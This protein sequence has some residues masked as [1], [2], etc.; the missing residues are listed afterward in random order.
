MSYLA[1]FGNDFDATLTAVATDSRINVLSKPR[2]QTSDG[3]AASLKV[4]N[5]VPYVTGTYFGGINGQ[6]SSQYTQTFVGIDL[7]VT[8]QI[9]SEGLVVMDISQDVEQLGPTTEIDGNAVP[10]TTQR[11]AVSTVSVK[12]RDTIILGG[13]IS[14]TKSKSHSGVPGLKDIPLLGY[15]F[16]SSSDSIQRVELIV[17]IRS[18]VLPTPDKA[19]AFATE[20]RN[21]MPGLKQAEYDAR[22]DENKRLKRADA[23][24]LP[25]ERQ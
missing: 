23:I 9:N 19:A 24:T 3:V 25:P 16:R 5:T 4:G 18:T 15:L 20:M 13:F 12:D 7:E 8:P 10:T 14:N 22:V 2:I 6:A 11:T 1:H 21:T 17:L